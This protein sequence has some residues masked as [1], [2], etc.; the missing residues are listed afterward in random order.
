MLSGDSPASAAGIAARLGLTDVRAGLLPEDKVRELERLMAAA[1]GTTAFVGD[2]TNDAP[3]LARADLGVALGGIGSD[4]AIETADMVIL[5]EDP[6]KLAVAVRLA[7][8]TQRTIR[9]NIAMAFSVKLFFLIGAA[10][11]IPSLW[12]AVFA[13]VGVA[14]LAILNAS[15]LLRHE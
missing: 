8:R 14:L 7:R 13:D 12:E 11:G 2:G 3:V 5:G 9:Q 15:H 4:A 10:F 1:G 6:G